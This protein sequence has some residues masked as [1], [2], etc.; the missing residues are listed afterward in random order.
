M[1]K[2]LSMAL[3]L[4]CGIGLLAAPAMAQ[5][6]NPG[7]FGSIKRNGGEGAA[8]TT[9]G[10][11]GLVF[12]TDGFELKLTTRVQFRLT[13]QNE[14][15]HGENGQNGRDFI[16]FRVRRVK[17]AFSGYI[18]QKEFQYKLV[19]TF[20]GGG[21]EIVEE[22]WFRWAV[23][24]YINIQAGQAK[25]PWNW[26]EITSSGSQQFV[27]RGYVNEVFNQDFAKG[28]TLDGKVG[29]DV[30]WLKYWVGIYNGRLKDSDDFRNAD[31]T[32]ISD[33]FADGLVDGDMMLNL[34]LETHPLG[35][36]KPSLN[37]GR[38]DDE[39][40]KVLFA[41]GLA[42]NWF[43]SGFNNANIRPDTATGA[44]G[45]GRSRTSQDTMAFTADGHFRWHG[46]S[47]DV[48]FFWRHTEFHNRG[49]NRYSPTS[50][51]HNGAANNTDMGI[52]FDVSYFILPKQLNVG[53]RYNWLNADEHWQNGDT[54]RRAGLRPDATEIGL[55]VNYYV[56]GDNLKLTFDLLYVSEQLAS[57]MDAD[58]TGSTE[59]LDGV[60]TSPPGR[61]AGSI[62]GESSDYADTWIIRLQLQWIF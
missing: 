6:S 62:A 20:A 29:E 37:D 33:T 43:V 58:N 1:S 3:V 35:D 22:A 11:K 46:L 18:F 27:D 4:L 40:D 51:T 45:S 25:L 28:I 52:T 50:P 26:E 14:V 41:V 42:V 59:G 5:D 55:S 48:A 34:R 53:V 60:Y 9:L 19:L 7:N 47:A 12:T 61:S 2:L 44:T 16:N 23:M 30:S 21:D 56:H 39:Y 38:G 10:K 24:D 36:V 57:R 8:D 31:V 54:S 17:S 49:R 15:G 13:Y 32:R